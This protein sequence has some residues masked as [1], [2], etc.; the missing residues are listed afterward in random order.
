MRAMIGATISNQENTNT[1]KT[2]SSSGS[3][4]S[5]ADRQKSKEVPEALNY[6][7]FDAG[8]M[9]QQTGASSV[10]TAHEIGGSQYFDGAWLQVAEVADWRGDEPEGGGH[11]QWS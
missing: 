7:G 9:E 6:F 3:R 11:R 10:L 5:S 2:R 8:V 4:I 1:R